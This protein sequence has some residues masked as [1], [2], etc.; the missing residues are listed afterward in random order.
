MRKLIAGLALL[1]A[2]CST[3]PFVSDPADTVR[4][5][6]GQFTVDGKT[7]SYGCSAVV[8]APNTAYTA[9]HCVDGMNMHVDRLPITKVVPSPEIDLALLTVPGLACPCAEIGKKPEVGSPV[10]AVG[11]PGK[12]GKKRTTEEATVRLIGPA[13]EILSFFDDPE[14]YIYT[15]KN[16][17]ERGDSGGGLF[18][19]QGYSW[20]LVGITSHIIAILGTEITSGFVPVYE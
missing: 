15:N 7:K 18:Q 8:I 11:F 16:I 3:I 1:L 20:K 9:K 13:S 4:Q 5:L 17:V 10:K 6:T 2:A 19:R 12:S 14:L